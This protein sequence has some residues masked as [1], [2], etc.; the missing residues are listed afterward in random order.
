MYERAFGHELPGP[1]DGNFLVV[2]WPDGVGYIRDAFDFISDQRQFGDRGLPLRLQPVQIESGL[3]L[4][5]EDFSP[6]EVRAIAA[7]DA[8]YCSALTSVIADDISRHAKKT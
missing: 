6:W 7:M 3:R 5:G 8:A 1:V 2:E 4:M